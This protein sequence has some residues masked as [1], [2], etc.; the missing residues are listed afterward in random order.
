VKQF[1]VTLLNGGTQNAG[2]QITCTLTFLQFE[3][4]ITGLGSQFTFLE[5][6]FCLSIVIRLAQQHGTLIII[7]YRGDT[8]W[9]QLPSAAADDAQQSYCNE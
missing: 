2:H 8:L 1:V 6:E 7:A 5:N 4:I 3:L 9:R